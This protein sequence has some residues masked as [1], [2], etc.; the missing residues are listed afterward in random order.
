[1]KSWVK[2]KW[3]ERPIVRGYYGFP[4]ESDDALDKEGIKVKAQEVVVRFGEFW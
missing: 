2:Q 3:K 4:D 1:M